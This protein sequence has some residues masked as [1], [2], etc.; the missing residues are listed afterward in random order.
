MYQRIQR[1][2]LLYAIKFLISKKKSI[3]NLI[4]T[5]EYIVNE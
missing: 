4:A 5:G 1:L 3:Y 2:Q